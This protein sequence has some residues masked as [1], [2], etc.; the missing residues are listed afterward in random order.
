M[1]TTMCSAIVLGCAVVAFGAAGCGKATSGQQHASGQQHSATS[2]S[3]PS[4]A[5]TSESP[6]PSAT[7]PAPA[8]TTPAPSGATPT[9]TSAPGDQPAGSRCTTSD[10]FAVFEPL[11]AAA[12]SQYGKILLTNHSESPCTIYGYGGIGLYSASGDPVPTHQMRDT[13]TP[14]VTVSLRPGD[15]AFSRLQWSDVPGTGESDTSAC[16]PQAAQLRVIPPDETRALDAHWPG[17]P[18][19]QHGQIWQTA[20]RTGTGPAAGG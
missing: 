18:A 20:Y 12:G 2:S 14:P 17:S 4:R 16:E 15:H 3:D 11:G 8:T 6:S 7:T 9:P 13:S 10:L 19:C 1:R 5:A